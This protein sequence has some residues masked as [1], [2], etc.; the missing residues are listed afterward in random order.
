MKYKTYFLLLLFYL[1]F[2]I[3]YIIRWYFLIMTL[4]KHM[5]MIDAIL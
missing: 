1:F 4:L 5:L 3:A 2:N